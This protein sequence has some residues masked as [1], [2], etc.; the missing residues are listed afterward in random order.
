MRLKTIA[1]CTRSLVKGGAKHGIR[2]GAR[3]LHEF[4]TAKVNF[5]DSVGFCEAIL[6]PGTRVMA[7]VTADQQKI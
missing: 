6:F 4:R 3:N 2:L 5:G 7:Q 1:N